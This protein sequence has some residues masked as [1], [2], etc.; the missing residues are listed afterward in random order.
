MLK[1]VP[2]SR[3][4]LILVTSDSGNVA[5]VA[6]HTLLVSRLKSNFLMREVYVNIMHTKSE[7]NEGWCTG[8]EPLVYRK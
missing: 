3:S 6:T 2:L 7:G 5:K 8:N 1:K 4:G